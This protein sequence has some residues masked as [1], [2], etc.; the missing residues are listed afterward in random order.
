MKLP[1]ILVLMIDGVQELT[2]VSVGGYIDCT[3]L[4]VKFIEEKLV[5]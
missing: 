2:E 1:V 4:F 3:T 5:V